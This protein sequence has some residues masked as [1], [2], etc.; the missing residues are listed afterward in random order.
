MVVKLDKV[1]PFGR[2]LDEYT[3]IFSLSK[4]DLNRKILGVGDGPASFNAV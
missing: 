1:I 3:K 2:S 4:S